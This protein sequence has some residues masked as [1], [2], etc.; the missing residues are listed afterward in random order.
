METAMRVWRRY[1]LLALMALTMAAC[2]GRTSGLKAEGGPATKKG[3]ASPLVTEGDTLWAERAD[4]AKAEAAVKKWEAAAAQDP[5]RA[6]VQ[7]KLAYGYYFLANAHA[8]WDEDPEDQMRALFLKGV[9]TAERA[10]KLQ[11]PEFAAK[12]KGGASWG[13]A[14]TSVPKEGI[15]GLYWY[16]TNLGKWGLLDGITTILAHKDDIY[17]TMDHVRGL[18][19]NFF[20]GAAH[21]YFGVYWAKL[22]FGKDLKKSRMHFEKSIELAPNYLETKVLFA[23][24]WAARSDD[25]ALFK[26][27]LNEVIATPVNVDATL[28]PEN[29]NAKR[30]AQRMLKNI[31]D[32]F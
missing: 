13:E 7:L 15:A 14:V 3:D 11:S 10:I 1:G 12:I 18:D 20:H 5:T 23:E 8:K 21:R 29:Q 22:P 16:A 6:D 17:K 4:R 32:F 26:K 30:T 25:E 9:E 24:H 31:D 28:I 2:G 19:E 27:L